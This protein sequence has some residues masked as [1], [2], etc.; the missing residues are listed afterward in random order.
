MNRVDTTVF[1]TP[2]WT[3]QGLEAFL[4]SLWVKGLWRRALRAWVLAVGAVFAASAATAREPTVLNNALLRS[5][6]GVQLS[7]RLSLEPSR[8]VE[9]ALLKGIPVYFVWQSEV[10]RER[11]YWTDKR[12]GSAT[13]TLRLAYQPLTRRWRVSLSTDGASSAAGL[14]Y[15]LHQSFDAL[16]DALLGISR[17]AGWQII[18]PGTLED[19]VPYRVQWRFRLDLSLLPRPFQI[20]M[21]NQ[22][23]WV[24]EVQRGLLVPERNEPEPRPDAV[25]DDGDAGSR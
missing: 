9:D 8:A 14:Q 19:G 6:D 13:R 10:F 21:A 1:I 22:P 25:P 2:G 11:W 5:G 17:V 20:G 12:I 24:M 16:N 3:R 15:A 18:E 23:D 4:S 7:V